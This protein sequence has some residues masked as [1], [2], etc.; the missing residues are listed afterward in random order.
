MSS[1]QYIRSPNSAIETLQILLERRV[2]RWLDLLPH[3]IYVDLSASSSCSTH[4]LQSDSCCLQCGTGRAMINA[5]KVQNERIALLVNQ[6]GV[7][8]L[9][10][11]FCKPS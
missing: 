7:E 3:Y 6:R 4:A 1:G 5:A 8:H 10:I 9:Q 2:S 11:R